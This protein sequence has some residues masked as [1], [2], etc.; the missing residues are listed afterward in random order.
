MTVYNTSDASQD[1]TMNRRQFGVGATALS[2]GLVG[3][4]ALG[5]EEPAAE[6]EDQSE[7]KPKVKLGLIG[8]GGRG[9]WIAK[10]T[11]PTASRS[12]TTVLPTRR[13]RLGAAG[14]D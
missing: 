9:T 8:C 7:T 6:P 10:V 1:T 2:F 14:R 13:P 3:V 4:Q 5:Q 11:A 12:V